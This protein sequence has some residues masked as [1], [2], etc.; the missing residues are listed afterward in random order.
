MTFLAGFLAGLAV[1]PA[2]LAA[3]WL[4]DKVWP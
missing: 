1:I 3:C 4:A 2:C